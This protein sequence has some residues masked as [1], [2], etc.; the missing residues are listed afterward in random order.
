MAAAIWVWRQPSLETQSIRA[1]LA[2]LTATA[3]A[4]ASVAT[5]FD[6]GV[7]GV[8]RVGRTESGT[9]GAN[10]HGG[11]YESVDG[12]LTWTKAGEGYIPLEKLGLMEIEEKAPKGIL[13]KGDVR[14]TA[15]EVLSSGDV[16]YSFKYLQ[17]G[18][19]Q[20]DAGSG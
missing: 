20:V 8:G 6:T 5:S 7:W 18:R 19:E 9:L 10:T 2:L 17:S 11:F 4:L 15:H 1:R 3:A 14:I 12:G 13:S 16:V